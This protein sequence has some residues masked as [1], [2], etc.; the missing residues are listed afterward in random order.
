M[1]TDAEVMEFEITAREC[2]PYAQDVIKS[3][4]YKCLS[5]DAKLL[6]LALHEKR[7]ISQHGK[8]VK[9]HADN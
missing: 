2:Q 8:L 6:L 3:T 1:A 5:P 4:G 9:D 7:Y